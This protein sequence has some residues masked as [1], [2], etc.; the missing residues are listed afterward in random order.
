V[1]PL[2]REHSQVLIGP[3]QHEVHRVGPEAGGQFS[4]HRAQRVGDQILRA[5]DGDRAACGL[6]VDKDPPGGIGA[7]GHQARV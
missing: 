4:S 1:Y 6:Q 2:G 3:H 5:G 7:D